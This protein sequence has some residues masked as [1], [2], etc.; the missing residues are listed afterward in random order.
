M[1]QMVLSLM[2][3]PAALAALALL[4]AAGALAVDRARLAAHLRQSRAAL[5]DPA[6]GETWRSEA[7]SAS[8]ALDRCRVRANTDARALRRQNLAIEEASRQADAMRRRLADRV[9]AATRAGAR[10]RARARDVLAAS[11]GADACTAADALI[12]RSLSPE[13]GAR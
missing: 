3:R 5:T 11:A 8:A 13:P 9:V 4:V 1:I 12:L 2:R 7:A 10:E 6:T